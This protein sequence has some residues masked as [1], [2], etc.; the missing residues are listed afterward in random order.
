MK[1]VAF[2]RGINVGGHQVI[3]MDGLK[4]T[5]ETMGFENVKT[6]LASGNVLFETSEK[7]ST[8]SQKIEDTLQKQYGYFIAV[9]VRSNP[10][11]QALVDADP[12]HNIPVTKET[13]LYVTF[14]YEKN[15]SKL[16]VPY[17]TQDGNFKIL[18]ATDKEVCS[19]LIVTPD[20]G[21]PAL[22]SI[23]E[24]EYCKN[25][26]TRNWNTVKKAILLH[27]KTH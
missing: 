14:L 3:K 1:F 27:E 6:L 13:R 2:L 21:T 10:E 12:F 15:T 7:E 9:I 5:F 16:S 17:E 8:L 4:K 19:V 22:M 11:L 18:H 26:T 24:K 23:L 25:I 20:R